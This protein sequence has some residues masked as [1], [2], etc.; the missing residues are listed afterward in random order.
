MLSAALPAAAQERPVSV[1]AAGAV[2]AP[3]SNGADRFRMGLGFTGRA[4]WEFADQ[5]S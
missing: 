2:T 1:M 4:A 3:L 5:L